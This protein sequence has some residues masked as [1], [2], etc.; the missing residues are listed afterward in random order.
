M[1]SRAGT[2]RSATASASRASA[3]MTATTASTRVA[4]RLG[5]AV[6]RGS[7]TGWALGSS[8]HE[9]LARVDLVPPVVAQGFVPPAAPRCRRPPHDRILTGCQEAHGVPSRGRQRWRAAAGAGH[10]KSGSCRSRMPLGQGNKAAVGPTRGP[11]VRRG[12]CRSESR[13]SRLRAGSASCSREA[14]YVAAQRRGAGLAWWLMPPRPRGRC[15]R[16]VRP[17]CG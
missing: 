3:R 16:P 14:V 11:P 6:R 9:P 12:V 1:P 17:R 8:I 15:P 10:V 13:R 7:V 2:A 5:F 4:T